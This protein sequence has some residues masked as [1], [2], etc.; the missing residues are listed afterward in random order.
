M[1]RLVEQLKQSLS[2]FDWKVTASK[3]QASNEDLVRMA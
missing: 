1:H 3:G 2:G